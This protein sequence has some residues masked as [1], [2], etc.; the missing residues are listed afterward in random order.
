M[1]N[2]KGSWLW[3]TKK[4]QS[5]IKKKKKGDLGCSRWSSAS[6]PHETVTYDHGADP[7]TETSSNHTC[8]DCEKCRTEKWLPQETGKPESQAQSFW[9]DTF[10]NQNS[11]RAGL[12][13]MEAQHPEE[14]TRPM[15]EWCLKKSTDRSQIFWERFLSGGGSGRVWCRLVLPVG[16]SLL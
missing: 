3:I 2:L 13:K 4:I 10:R 5:L 9:P 12:P 16:A 14:E 6:I 15:R 1:Y 8:E 7:Q 11:E